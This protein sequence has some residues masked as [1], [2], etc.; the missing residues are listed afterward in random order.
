MEKNK[1]L[2][3]TGFSVTERIQLPVGSKVILAH[4]PKAKGFTYD[5]KIIEIFPEGT[6]D[7][8]SENR[9][10][11][12][13]GQ[14]HTTIDGTA[15]NKELFDWMQSKNLFDKNGIASIEAKVVEVGYITMRNGVSRTAYIFKT[16][17]KERVEDKPKIVEFQLR[18]KGSS[19]EFPGKTEVIKSLLDGENRRLFLKK[20]ED[21]FVSFYQDGDDSVLSGEMAEM[22]VGSIDQLDAYVSALAEQD[23]FAEII[24][25]K[26]VKGSTYVAKL[27][28]D[29]QTFQ[30][31]LTGKVVETLSEVRQ[32]VLDEGICSEDTLLEIEAYLKGNNVSE[33]QIKAIFETYKPYDESVVSRIPNPEVKYKDSAGLVKKS[34][35]YLNKGKHLR[36]VGEKGVGKNVL[37]ETMAWVYQRPL[38]EMALNAQTDKMD[39]LGS[40]TF[41][42]F[43]DENG[44]EV[45]KMTF[46]TEVLVQAMEV[47]GFMNLD[48]INTA[49]PSILVLL[50]PIA[51]KRRRLEVPGYGKV[52]ADKNFALLLS[53]NQDY[54]G[55]TE[56]NEATVDRFTPIIFPANE[57]IAETLKTCVPY[58]DPDHIS[59]CDR[60]YN[61]IMKLV[62]NGEI[63]M[64]CVTTRGFI[65]ALEVAEDL[66]FQ[67]AL[68]DNIANRISDEDY[69]NTVISII[70]DIVG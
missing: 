56:L 21:K 6:K 69:R 62:R 70:D 19:R 14:P 47:G 36:Y 44:N 34:V 67:E 43:V 28:V 18:F 31:V 61:S 64:K 3:V 23:A 26:I 39:I 33:K 55:T 38:Y 22:V 59:Q 1:N 27:E 35:V 24:A 42:S 8:D 65:D 7:F 40:K 50:H 11:V 20:A 13:G 9:L 48:E 46:D 51:D 60:V 53:M 25:V 45:S 17:F 52:E 58:A 37:I 16:N 30:D 2:L 63:S 5:S 54:L 4:N 29:Q 10:G 57:S 66:D 12:I 41:E 32:R 49:D 68:I 15:T